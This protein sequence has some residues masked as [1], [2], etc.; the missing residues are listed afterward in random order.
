M[1]PLDLDEPVSR[2]EAWKLLPPPTLHE[3]TD[4]RFE[5]FLPPQVDGHETAK[6]MPDGKAVIVIDN[7]T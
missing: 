1:V 6:T 2:R 3:V 4:D 5:K 7:G